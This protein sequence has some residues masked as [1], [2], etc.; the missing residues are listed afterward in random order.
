MIMELAEGEKIVFA[1][2]AELKG[3]KGKLIVTN[4]KLAFTPEA[5]K[6]V[7]TQV[8]WGN[9][10]KTQKNNPAKDKNGRVG[11]RVEMEVG[12]A[13]SFFL[14]GDRMEI[15]T[16][17]QLKLHNECQKVFTARS[18]GGRSSLPPAVAEAKKRKAAELAT[19]V[20]ETD[21]ARKSRL[22]ALRKK[23]ILEADAHL[24]KSYV[25]CYTIV[26]SSFLVF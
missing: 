3:E 12:S 7:A 17:E 19:V 6:G 10:K 26:L 16:A 14:I 23:Q 18:E 2:K 25:F 4:V 21:V 11:F 8:P 15:M 13:L 5:N 9:I 24:G 1:H 22:L 20:N